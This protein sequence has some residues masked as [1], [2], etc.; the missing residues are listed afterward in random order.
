MFRHL[1]L[2]IQCFTIL[3]AVLYLQIHNTL[4][5]IEEHMI[6]F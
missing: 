6:Y 2:S 5:L 3:F 4:Q 1:P